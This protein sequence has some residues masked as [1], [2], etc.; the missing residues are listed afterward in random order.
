MDLN[1]QLQE[2]RRAQRERFEASKAA[3][4]LDEAVEAAA[5]EAPRGVDSPDAAIRF[6]QQLITPDAGSGPAS[7]VPTP[8]AAAM[9]MTFVPTGPPPTAVPPTQAPPSA[10]VSAAEER[11]CRICLSGEEDQESGRLF[12]PCRCTGT[13]QLVH[14]NCLQAWRSHSPDGQSYFRCGTCLYEYRIERARIAEFLLLFMD[15]RVAQVLVAVLVFCMAFAVGMVGVWYSPSLFTRLLTQL[16][17]PPDVWKVVLLTSGNPECWDA[18]FSFGLCCNGPRGDPRCWVGGFTF[19]HCCTSPASLA[20]ASFADVLR[21][22]LLPPF[23]ALFCG[24]SVLSVFGFARY[25]L[26][27]VVESLQR[28][29]DGLFHLGMSAAWFSCLRSD[30]LGRVAIVVGVGVAVREMYDLYG[31]VVVHAKFAAQRL[32][33]R[34]LE[35]S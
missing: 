30:E 35:V 28:G 3:A 1:A 11:Q 2:I 25:V 19:E 16:K 7:R 34:V 14:V 32:G 21:A 27:T 31:K 15:D 4:A 6:M 24:V 26:K 33:E 10:P 29:A 17:P 12:A 5:P 18:E 9:P 22:K 23:Q 20:Q 8:P 13:A